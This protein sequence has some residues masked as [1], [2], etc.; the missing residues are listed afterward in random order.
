[1]GCRSL[2]SSVPIKG[3]K[4]AILRNLF[5]EQ[6]VYNNKSYEILYGKFS[7]FTVIDGKDWISNSCY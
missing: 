5:T 1:M 6:Y 3:G 4:N 2:R 7:K